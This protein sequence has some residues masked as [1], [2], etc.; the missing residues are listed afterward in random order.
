MKKRSNIHVFKE[1]RGGFY[2]NI[3]PIKSAENAY[4]KKTNYREKKIICT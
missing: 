4:A 3:G 2:G 1:L